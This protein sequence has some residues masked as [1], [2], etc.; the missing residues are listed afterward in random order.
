MNFGLYEMTRATRTGSRL[1][2]SLPRRLDERIFKNTFRDIAHISIVQRQRHALRDRVLRH[3]HLYTA[4]HFLERS[5]SGRRSSSSRCSGS[6]AAS[7]RTGGRAAHAAHRRPPLRDDYRWSVLGAGRN[8]M[9][10]ATMSAV[11]AATSASGS[12]TA[13]A[14]Q[15]SS[16]RPTRAGREDPPASSRSWAS[17]RHARRGARHPEAER[18]GQRELLSHFPACTMKHRQPRRARPRRV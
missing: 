17:S 13:L 12:R 11:M 10:V 9:Y 2:T 18:Q 4:A 16:R 3:R 15:G 14:R 1:G 5:S 7:G 6:A 8:Q